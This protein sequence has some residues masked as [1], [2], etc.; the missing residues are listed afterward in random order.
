MHEFCVAIRIDLSQTVPFIVRIC[1]LPAG[2]GRSHG[3]HKF[4]IPVVP[5]RHSFDERIF[6]HTVSV[7]DLICDPNLNVG[8]LLPLLLLTVSE[9]K[10]LLLAVWVSRCLLLAVLVSG[11]LS[12]TVSV[13]LYVAVCHRFF[14][15][16]TRIHPVR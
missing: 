9:F 6:A 16:S 1:L 14:Q 12:L 13:Y 5:R 7:S 4:H 11:C 10:C 2:R 8:E 3:P 15:S